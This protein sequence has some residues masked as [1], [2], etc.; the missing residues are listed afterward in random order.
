M[1]ES[2]AIYKLYEE[3]K[4]ELSKLKKKIKRFV[5]LNNQITANDIEKP[6]WQEWSNLLE[7]LT[8]E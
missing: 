2:E 6:I 1:N 3:T 4:Q 8:N 7:E 5:K